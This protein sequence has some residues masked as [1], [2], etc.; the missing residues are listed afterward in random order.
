MSAIVSLARKYTLEVTFAAFFVVNFAAMWVQPEWETVPLHL[1]W[2]ALTLVY[3]VRVWRPLVTAPL[4]ALLLLVT[5]GAIVRMV[6]VYSEPKAE[7]AEVPLVGAMFVAMAWH[8]RRHWLATQ[9]VS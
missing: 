5:G 3:G 9:E 1:I 2:V 4:V 6:M 7:I 8:A